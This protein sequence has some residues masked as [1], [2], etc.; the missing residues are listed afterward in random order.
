V[1]VVEGERKVE[2]VNAMSEEYG[3]HPVTA[4][5]S[6]SAQ[7]LKSHS[8]DIALRLLQLAPAAVLLWPDNDAPGIS[9]MKSI[10]NSLVQAN[11]VSQ[12][13]EPP[14][15]SLGPGQDVVDHLMN[16]DSV[17][18][19]LSD[20]W[21]ALNATR[22]GH[23]TT[24]QRIDQLVSETVMLSAT[25]F[26]Y[27]ATQNE[28]RLETV[29]LQALWL[30]RFKAMP[31]AASIA[32]LKAAL[33]EKGQLHAVIKAY[34]SYSVENMFWWRPTPKDPIYQVS[35]EGTD[36]VAEIPGVTLLNPTQEPRYSS[37]VDPGEE[38]DFLEFC[39]RF[40]LSEQERIMVLSW[41]VSAFTGR[42]SPI[43]LFK[44]NAATG[45]TTLA[46]A[47]CAVVDPDTPTIAVEGA[48]RDKREFIR[49][50]QTHPVLLID[51]VSSMPGSFEDTLA[52][53]VTGD[54]TDLRTLYE[55]AVESIR[56]QR[57]IAITTTT[58]DVSKGDLA[59]RI[60][61]IEPRVKS[62]FFDEEDMQA[63][64]NHYLPRIRGFVF[65]RCS[66]FYKRSHELKDYSSFLRVAGRVVAALGYNDAQLNQYIRDARAK[67]LIEGDP[68]L[69]YIVQLWG[70]IRETGPRRWK[71]LDIANYVSDKIHDKVSPETMGRYI[72]QKE[73][74]FQDYGFKV[75][76]NRIRAGTEYLFEEA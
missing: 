74:H 54:T 42:K 22:N 40:G 27:P 31:P 70:E 47:L 20:Y 41:L 11:V 29:P 6:G 18:R 56:L 61:P 73:A 48:D 4:F 2:Y 24:R 17:A 26:L 35:A 75:R 19:V 69:D 46:S 37:R 51:N 43:L 5:T 10:R 36:Q 15:Y 52:K 50:V 23:S 7:S 32:E 62:G 21:P 44:G 45:K 66:M 33:S 28:T 72:R 55:D 25:R 67:V 76:R 68:W 71:A 1:I 14:R 3:G 16:G 13:V 9:A 57:A 34:Q 60:W 39:N 30:G 58:W 64:A 8:P 12:T 53:I 49:T 59:T 63:L 65:E 38:A